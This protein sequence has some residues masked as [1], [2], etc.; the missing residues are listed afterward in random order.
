M[1]AT[2]IV[3]VD[4][5]DNI[6]ALLAANFEIDRRFELVGRA[7][8][9]RAAIEMVQQLRPDAVLMDLHMP[10]LD[11]VAATRALLA[12]M[13]DACIIAFTSSDDPVEHQAARDAGAT[14]VLR[15]PFDPERFLD[16]LAA[17]AHRCAQTAT[18]A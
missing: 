18:A 2:R 11:G 14:A 15:K 9:G 17:H 13:P 6:A 3:L 12:Q 8:D 4:D 10:V 16:G 1:S 5:D 7:R